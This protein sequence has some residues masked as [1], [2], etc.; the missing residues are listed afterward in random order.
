MP[1]DAKGAPLSLRIA[2]GKA[3]VAK[4]SP[5]RAE[6]ARRFD[7]GKA[8]ATAHIPTEMIDDGERIAVHAIARAELPFEIDR[9][10]LIGCGGL[11]RCRPRMFPM[12]A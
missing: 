1:S 8:L 12:R 6:H 9:P 2:S 7:V 4:E 3:M 5:Q 10:H 11:Q